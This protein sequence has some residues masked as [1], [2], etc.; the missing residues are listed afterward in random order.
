[1]K[2][3]MS[4]NLE[5]SANAHLGD[6]QGAR[7]TIILEVFSLDFVGAS[8]ADATQVLE[9]SPESAICNLHGRSIRRPPHLLLLCS[10]TLYF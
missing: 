8:E 6:M 3:V 1:M 5:H 4:R 7:A 9:C 10:C 2:I